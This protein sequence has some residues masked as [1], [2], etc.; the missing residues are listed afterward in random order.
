MTWK[1]PAGAARAPRPSR[2]P[3]SQ[4]A[5]HTRSV[6]QATLRLTSRARHSGT[7][8][9]GSRPEREGRGRPAL[10]GLAL[11]CWAPRAEQPGA[12]RTR[13]HSPLRAPR[14]SFRLPAAW[15]R[16]AGA[17]R[18]GRV[19]QHGM[20][21]DLSGPPPA[22]SAS[23]THAHTG[24]QT[25]CLHARKTPHDQAAATGQMPAMPRGSLPR[26]SVSMLGS[27]V[28]MLGACILACLPASGATRQR[29]AGCALLLVPAQA[30]T[31]S[32]L[33]SA[34]TYVPPCA[35]ACARAPSAD[36]PS[37]LTRA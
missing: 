5:A 35:L 3:A 16:S 37:P 11:Q 27:S 21:P 7:R 30:T 14:P 32:P 17:G 8:C 18:A 12:K 26:S 20:R 13:L 2:R 31:L 19:G 6:Q 9:I 4:A 23:A 1:L 10:A 29:R 25:L 22:A 15:R 33:S 34:R 24:S 28:C 36:A